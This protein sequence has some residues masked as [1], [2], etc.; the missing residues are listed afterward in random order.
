MESADPSAAVVKK[1]A[2][3]SA[4]FKKMSCFVQEYSPFDLS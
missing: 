2:D 4:V 3:E 1:T